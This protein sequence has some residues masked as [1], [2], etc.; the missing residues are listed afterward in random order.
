MSDDNDTLRDNDG[1]I[2]EKN[3]AGQYEKKWDFLGQ[4]YA[5]DRVELEYQTVERTIDGTALY[6]RRESPSSGSGSS[7][8]SGLEGIISLI[9]AAILLLLLSLGTAIVVTPILAPILLVKMERAQKR[10]NLPKAKKWESWGIGAIV[11]AV[12]VV[13]GIALLIGFAMFAAIGV[14]SQ[15]TTSPILTG[16]IYLLAIAV[17]LVASALSFVTG[18]S[19]TAIVYLRQKEEHLRTSGK[20]VTAKRIRQLNRAIGIVA[21]G[22]VALTVMVY[23]VLIIIIIVTSLLSR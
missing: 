10:G 8:S 13:F 12:P 20:S 22:T 11:F 1:Y 5:R 14:L 4:D 15:N 19:P 21:A 7:S 3:L 17:G 16:L 2:Y 18:I 6:R 23:A 9:G